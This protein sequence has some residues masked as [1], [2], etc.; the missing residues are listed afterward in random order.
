MTP[1]GRGD[2]SLR[3]Y[4]KREDYTIHTCPT[5]PMRC[6]DTSVELGEIDYP[7]DEWLGWGRDDLPHDDPRWPKVCDVCGYSFMETDHW[8][9]NL[10][11]LFT[12]SPD[13]KLYSTRNMP[14]GAMY[15]APWWDEKGADGLALVVVTPGDTHWMPDGPSAN[16]GKPWTRT[17]AVPKITVTPSISTPRYHG[18]LTDGVLIEC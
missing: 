2:E 15:D 5:N 16:G 9:H 4:E 13:G 3:R 7:M 11:R 6:H 14:A 8:Q 12:G 17:G 10:V 1:V 18:F